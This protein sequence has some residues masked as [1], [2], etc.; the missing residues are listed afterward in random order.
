MARKK[1]FSIDDIMDAALQI[2]RKKGMGHLTARS[3]A[4][5]LG[6]STMPIYSCVN[7]MREIEEAVVQKS[8]EILQQYQ[9]ASRS[10]DIYTDM[11]LG[12]VLFAKEE[13]HLFKCIH[14]EAYENINTKC[15]E[16]NFELLLR[17][18]E[19]YPLTKNIPKESKEK[20]LFRGFLFC[21]GFASLLNSSMGKNLRIL[22]TEKAI[23]NFFKE[24]SA[25]AWDGLKSIME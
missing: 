22:D 17:R 12:Y 9:L 19:E 10:G 15:G 2:V 24:S 1:Q 8:W 20:L 16:R 3:I 7:S 13:K 21:H 18:L 25:I 6:A 11:G 14:N 23:V 5:A 4:K